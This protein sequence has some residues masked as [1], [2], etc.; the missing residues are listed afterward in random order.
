MA[1]LSFNKEFMGLCKLKHYQF[2]LKE[3][4]TRANEGRL[5]RLL[6]FYGTGQ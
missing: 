2:E 6:T 1:R 5:L 4:E 3:T